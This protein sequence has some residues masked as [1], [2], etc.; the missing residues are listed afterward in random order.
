MNHKRR[1]SVREINAQLRFIACGAAGQGSQGKGPH[2]LIAQRPAQEVELL[3]K[4]PKSLTR[5]WRRSMRETSCWRRLG[6]WRATIVTE[7]DGFGIVLCR[8]FRT[9]EDAMACC[10]EL[11]EGEQ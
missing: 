4:L 8:R 5:G 7:R 11:M 9:I 10:N 1:I 3:D 6:D 2:D